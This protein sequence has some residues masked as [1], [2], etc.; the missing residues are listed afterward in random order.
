[1]CT[2]R[3][4]HTTPKKGCLQSL[5]GLMSLTC[6]SRSRTRCQVFLDAT[7]ALCNTDGLDSDDSC[8]AGPWS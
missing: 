5:L 1:M 7:H 6:L 4:T 2:V 3:R 8:L